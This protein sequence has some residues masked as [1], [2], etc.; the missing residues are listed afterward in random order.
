MAKRRPSGDGMVRKREDGRWEG[1]IVIGHK[2]KG[3][4]LVTGDTKTYAGTRTIVLPDST[5]EL[6]RCRKKNSYSVWIF[7]NP[8]KP[9][10][11]MNPS[12]AYRQLKAIL[13]E[14]S[15]PDLRFHDLRHTFATHALANGVDAKTLSGILG[16]T[17]ASFTVDTYT[18]TTTDMHRK[19]AEIVG[20]FLTDY[21]ER[22]WLH[23]KAQKPRRRQPPPEKRW[24]LGRAVC[25][26]LR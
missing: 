10:A 6:L 24:P 3:G 22:R 11:P 17:K 12:I 2:E 18:H 5:A 23:G 20:G 14:N 26:G 8:L 21:R 16:H 25:G 13:T 1:R 19:A 9:E 7:P 4:R 15:L